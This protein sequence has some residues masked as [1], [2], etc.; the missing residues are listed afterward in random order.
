[1]VLLIAVVVVA[2]ALLV[3][4]PLGPR[5]A[6]APVQITGSGSQLVVGL[7]PDAFRVGEPFVLG[8]TMR[9]EVAGEVAFP[10]LLTLDERLEQTG[11]VEV[12]VSEDGREW[13]AYYTLVGW[14]V[15]QVEIP[16]FGVTRVA[17]G[18]ETPQEVMVRPPAV[19]VLSVLPPEE[20]EVELREARPYLRISGPPWTWLLLGLLA[21]L[22]LWLWWRR[23]TT[24]AAAGAYLTPGERALRSL[25]ELRGQW[26]RSE[27]TGAELFDGVEST[28]RDFVTATRHWRASRSLNALGQDDE[29]LGAALAR[30]ALVRFARLRTSLESS[31]GAIDAA[32]GFVR[33]ETG[34]ASVGVEPI[35]EIDEASGT[36]DS[37]PDD[38]DSGI[39]EPDPQNS[40]GDS[41]GDSVD[42]EIDAEVER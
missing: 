32:V 25:A 27:I 13:R 19:Q 31:L 30:S 14:Q 23:R 26:K 37:R 42:A 16:G 38:G 2:I 33:R 39:G 1:V 7:E 40:V 28:L 21:L 6:D 11:P 18:S 29:A 17:V 12:R 8:I 5:R 3:L 22:P 41:V 15:E 20:E 9:D 35:D 34:P 24:L 4:E 36:A 10:P